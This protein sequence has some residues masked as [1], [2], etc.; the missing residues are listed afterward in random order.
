MLSYGGAQFAMG[1][2]MAFSAYYL[3]MFCT[4]IAL[5]P[6]ATTAFLLLCYRLVSVVDDPVMGFSINRVH[7]KG[8]KYRPFLKLF[9]LPFAIGL[10]AFGLTPHI[11][12]AAR[13]LFA[14]F[15]LILCE[16]SRSAM[17]TASLSMLPYFA[18]DDKTRTKFVSFSNGSAIVAYIA[19]GTFMLPLAELFSKDDRAKGFSLTLVLYAAIA[20]PLLFNAW[21][22]LKE[23]YYGETPAKPAVRDLFA[24]I[25]G[26]RRLLM[27]LLGFCLYAMANSFKTQLVYY[28][29]TYNIGLPDLLPV[30]IFAGLISPLAMQPVIP[31]LL[32][33]AK[34]E[35]LVVF[36]VFAAS[37][38]SL[39]MLAA[40]NNP[41]ALIGCFVFYGLFTAIIANLIFAVI[42]SFTDEIRLRLNINM[43]EILTAALGLS[44]NLGITATSVLAPLAMSA[45]GYSA[46]AV[47]QTPAVLT[48]FKLLFIACTAAGLALSGIVL[49]LA[50]KNKR[51]D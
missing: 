30:V 17:S 12:P 22:R 42:A 32:T 35:S 50:F 31:R 27:V 23:R 14:V 34:K 40:G 7:L 25:T 5:I 39:T 51:P 36:G 29:V 46:Q 6:P 38:A 4:D 33:I 24:A 21:F 3:M 43:S 44:S 16:L 47:V 19:I 2:Y 49:L 1:I 11:D 37:C 9:A 10:T 15:T 20:L 13:V 41:F 8:G 45:F 26:N 48:G 18:K 28:Y